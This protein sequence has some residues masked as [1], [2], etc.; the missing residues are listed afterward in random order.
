MIIK[1]S[2]NKMQAAENFIGLMKIQIC[3]D[4]L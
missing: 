1:N 3:Y 2:F 4:K